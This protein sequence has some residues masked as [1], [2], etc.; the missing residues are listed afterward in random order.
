M[1]I[2][3]HEDRRLPQIIGEYLLEGLIERRSLCGGEGGAKMFRDIP[4]RKQ[5]ELALEQR[6]I[7]R[8]QRALTAE[9]LPAHERRARIAVQR[10]CARRV[11][12]TQIGAGAE[13]GEQ[14]K[15]A[16]EIG[17]QDRRSVHARGREQPRHRNIRAAILLRRR[18][19]HCDQRHR[20]VLAAGNGHRLGQRDPE[21]ATEAR[22]LGC[23]RKRC[24]GRGQDAGEP[25]R[26][27][28]EACVS[29][30]VVCAGVFHREVH[31]A[32]AF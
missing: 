18:R 27:R 5:I 30:V 6:P 8:R 31:Y 21:I 25:G 4:V 17:R 19:I 1:V 20:A 14:Q 23:G 26:E 12:G 28:S 2:A 24:R 11:Q 32:G 29:G 15:A 7:V 3:M 16:I 22:V 10:R 9:K 13:V